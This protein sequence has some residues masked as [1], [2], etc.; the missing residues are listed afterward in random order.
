MTTLE[1]FWE[2]VT[3]NPL[4]FVLVASDQ[5]LRIEKSL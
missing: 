2:H 3:S 4:W 1:K 5:P